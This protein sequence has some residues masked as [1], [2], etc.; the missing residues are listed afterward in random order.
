MANNK[1]VACLL[2]S[3]FE[4]SEFRIPYDRLR[5]AGY[6]VEIIGEKA[7]RLLEGKAGKEQ[8]K[9]DRGVEEVRPA[10]YAAAHPRRTLPRQPAKGRALRPLRARVRRARAPARGGVSRPAAVDGGAGDRGPHPHRVE[11]DPARSRAGAGAS[12]CRG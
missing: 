3:G 5:E 1:K 6:E 11:D 10:D 12:W 9:A 4:D 8:A 2:G 7:G